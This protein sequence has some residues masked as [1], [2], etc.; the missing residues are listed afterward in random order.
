[1]ECRVSSRQGSIEIMAKTFS[2]HVW[3]LLAALAVAVLLFRTRSVLGLA[4]D[5]ARHAAFAAFALGGV[6]LALSLVDR[7]LGS[8]AV[9]DIHGFKIDLSHG[10]TAI[11]THEVTANMGL[12]DHA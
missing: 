10:A 3:Y 12:P 5:D 2:N 6:P 8:R 9:V 1:M 7:V 11:R 4:E